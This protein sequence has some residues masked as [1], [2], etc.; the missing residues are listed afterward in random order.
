M[1]GVARVNPGVG[2]IIAGVVVVGAAVAGVVGLGA[3]VFDGVS[4][5]S[6]EEC[7]EQAKEDQDVMRQVVQ[8]L[9][10]SATTSDV[11]F[12]DACASLADSGYMQWTLR[13]KADLGA[14]RFLSAGWTRS[15]TE[16]PGSDP[17]DVHLVSPDDD[18]RIL[19]DLSYQQGVG[20]AEVD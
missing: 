20:H 1:T 14:E 19:V 4:V 15:D 2:V 17:Q 12:G 16:Y 7:R 8:P 13:S 5:Q 11:A 18:P 6:E 3:L 10:D 9:L